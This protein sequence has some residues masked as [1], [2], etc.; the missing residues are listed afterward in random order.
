MRKEFSTAALK[1]WPK[2][3]KNAQALIYLIL[4]IGVCYISYDRNFPLETPEQWK[5]TLISLLFIGLLLF[6]LARL[7]RYSVIED[8]FL[9]QYNPI[10]LQKCSTPIKNIA[11]IKT[12]F[13]RTMYGLH[14]GLYLKLKDG[15]SIKLISQLNSRKEIE[16]MVRAVSQ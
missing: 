14:K 4:M 5:S 16:G 2:I 9:V 12:N 13:V 6:A 10:T 7:C 15:T 8:A 11:E 3:F 1:Y